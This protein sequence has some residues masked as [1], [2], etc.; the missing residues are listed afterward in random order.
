MPEV[1]TN[2][3]IPDHSFAPRLAACQGC[4]AGATSFDISSG[5]T[6]IKTAM[7]QFEAALNTAGYLTRSVAATYLTLQP[8][9]LGDGNF[10]LDQP[11]PGGPSLTANQ[12]GALYNYILIAR[13]GASGVHN[14]TY[15][16]QLIVDSYTSLTGNVPPISLSRPN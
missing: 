16:K 11:R 2:R 12:A 1:T 13:G 3:G 15:T 10:D 4:H 8:T 7:L 5:Q 6:A 14:P 9:E